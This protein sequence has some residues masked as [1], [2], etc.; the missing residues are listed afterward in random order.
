MKEDEKQRHEGSMIEKTNAW[1]L[2]GK[3]ESKRSPRRI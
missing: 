2:V 1:N 3:P